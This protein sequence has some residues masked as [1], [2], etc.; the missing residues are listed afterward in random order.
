MESL[1]KWFN[2]KF[3]VNVISG[4]KGSQM[5]VL[6]LGGTK[7]LGRHI[8]EATLSR[9]HEVTLFNRGLENPNLFPNVE[10]L[11][12]NRDG[13]LEEL[14]GRSWDAV[15]DT[16]GYV[17]RV[18][19]DSAVMLA[20]SITH[21]TFISSISVYSDFSRLDMDEREPVGKLENEATEEVN[22]ETYG[23]LKAKCEEE[24][25]KAMP[26]RVLNIRPGLIV[27]P[28]D[29]SDRFTYWPTRIAQG[30]E[31][32]APGNGDQKVQFIDVRDLAEWIVRMVESRKTG[33]YN[34]TGPKDSLTMES[35]LEECKVSL[36]SDAN[37][38]WVSEEFLEQHEVQAWIDLPL[39]IP[40]SKQWP[41]FQT[42]NCQKAISD[43]LIFRP[44]SGTIR[45]TF[46][47]DTGRSTEKERRA[48]LTREREE[49]L[50]LAWIK[51]SIV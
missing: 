25:E 47:W 31:I 51:E 22:G 44:L 34:A 49:E 12:G 15:I 38:T 2:S 37:V 21:Y 5:K 19:R 23:P 45:D 33:T 1:I 9:D 17:P 40:Q 42:I 26:G 32:I 11:Q 41:G 24:A 3:R 46:Q 27:G 20:D 48:G 35:L 4:G 43:G 16:C 39:W 8:V 50:L 30:G 13:Q 10:K 28:Y 36:N 14:K 7:F 6:I 18:V 29:P